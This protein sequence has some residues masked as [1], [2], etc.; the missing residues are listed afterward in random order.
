[1]D[2]EDGVKVRLPLICTSCVGPRSAGAQTILTPYSRIHAVRDGVPIAYLL[3]QQ[4]VC[5]LFD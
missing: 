1:M 4:I 3:L 5:A 2:D